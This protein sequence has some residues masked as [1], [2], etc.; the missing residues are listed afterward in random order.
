[1]TVRRCLA[2]LA[3]VLVFH[4]VTAASQAPAP[5]HHQGATMAHADSLPVAQLDQVKR[6]TAR[7]RDVRDAVADGYEDIHVVIPNM[8][9]HYLKKALMDSTFDVAH[10][11]IL[12]YAPDAKGAMQLVAAEYAVPTSL[13]QQAPEGFRGSED[14]WFVNE[15]FNI[16]TLHV[17]VWKD[18]PAGVFYPTNP[19]VP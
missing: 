12:V 15:E 8:G 10:P 4:Q 5:A 11:E 14:Q 9:H 2:A 1:M 17:W 16:W 18:N 7:Y 13:S 6:A 3:G 19:N